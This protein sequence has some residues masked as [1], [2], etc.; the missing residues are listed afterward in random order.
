MHM[1][2]FTAETIKEIAE[3]LDCGFRVF[4]HKTTGELLFIPDYTD[5]PDIDIEPW[6][7][8][9]SEKNFLDYYEVYKWSSGEAYDIMNDFAEQ[10]IDKK[11]Q[12]RL[13]DALNK[14]KPFREFKFAIDNSGDYR[15]QWF[16]FKSKQQQI[17]VANQLE[18][19]RE[20]DE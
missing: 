3:Q 16:D 14:R 5:Y 18:A 1:N 9:E 13:Y 19:L 2:N 8:D 6:M 15:Q 17:L 7:E 12:N 20:R 4:I 10:L 11:L